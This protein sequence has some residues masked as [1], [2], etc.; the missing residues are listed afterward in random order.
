MRTTVVGK[1]F[2]WQLYNFQ[3]G[4]RQKKNI[5][6]KGKEKKKREIQKKKERKQQMISKAIV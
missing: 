6:K 4:K 5:R 1:E 3:K 2:S